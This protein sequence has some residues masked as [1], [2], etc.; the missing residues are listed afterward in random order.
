MTHKIWDVL[1]TLDEFQFKNGFK[2]F[3]DEDVVSIFETELP[4]IIEKTEWKRA[5]LWN[6]GMPVRTI[7][8]W[9]AL[10]EEL[11]YLEAIGERKPGALLQVS[12]IR[13]DLE[14]HYGSLKAFLEGD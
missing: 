8:E 12:I 10:F 13:K 1:K 14:Q 9:W 4:F 6:M 5:L 3:R 11:G 2:N 7:N